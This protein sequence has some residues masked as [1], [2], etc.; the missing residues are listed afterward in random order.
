MH[1][2]AYDAHPLS[3]IHMGPAK[4]A[5]ARVWAAALP[6]PPADILDAGTGTGQVSVL[7]A[8]LGH[9]VTGVDLAE[10]M[11][12]LARAKSMGMTNPLTL[13][14]GDAVAPPF[15][16][17]SFDVVTCRYLLWTLREPQVALANWYRLLRPGGRLVAVDS[18]WYA[19]GIPRDDSG[20]QHAD[21]A[22]FVR[23]YDDRVVAAL[24]LAE[25]DSIDA[26]A[27]AV[28]SAGFADVEV[29]PLQEI[30]QLERSLH[31]D[32]NIDVQLQFMIT[33]VKE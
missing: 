25:V 13:L 14:V 30:E 17:M 11:L 9:R 22:D 20:E 16:P 8:E 27:A 32:P 3:Q 4:D 29:T 33:A 10:G 18:T 31:P 2:D 5:W 1:A 6:P 15:P 21:R 28:W 26:M 23:L 7:L 12:N 24:P 19:G